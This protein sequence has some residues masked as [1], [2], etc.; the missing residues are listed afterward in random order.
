MSIMTRHRC[1]LSH[2]TTHRLGHQFTCNLLRTLGA[3]AIKVPSSG[4]TQLIVEALAKPDASRGRSSLASCDYMHFL[5]FPRQS[6]ER[7]N[8]YM[9]F[10]GVIIEESLI[11][12]SVLK[13]LK[14]EST[15]VGIVTEKHKTPWVKQWT[16]HNVL[17]P[18]EDAA[19]I[20][21]QI[22]YSLDSDHQ[23]FADFKTE[24]EHYVIFREKVF[25]INRYESQDYEA[26]TRYG[27][28]IG[29]P[30]Y[31]VDFSALKQTK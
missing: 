26:A 18:Q 24:E 15:D 29:L 2:E 8:L 17:I 23:W 7:Y 28:Q 6:Q 27:I 1:P 3:R 9:D 21:E 19:N 22:S 13:N 14:I 4:T 30:K 5:F 25:H 16:M 10:Q 20:A 31:Q 11:D 12:N